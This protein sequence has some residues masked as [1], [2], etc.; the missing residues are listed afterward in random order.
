MTINERHFIGFIR[1]ALMGGD[2]PRGMLTRASWQEQRRL[3]KEQ[4]VSGLLY[5]TVT[6]LP[7][8][9]RPPQQI[10][11]KLYSKV[12]YYENMNQLL[13]ERTLEIFK[14]YREIGLHP[15]L[16]KGPA[17]ATLYEHPEQRVFGDIDIYVPD[18]QNRLYDWATQNA[19]SVSYAPGKEHLL[20]FHWRG[21]TIE[22]HLCLLKFYNKTLA[23]RM[24][25]IVASELGGDY[26]ETFVKI[27]G[28]EVEVLPRTLGL[29]YDIVH[30]SKHLISSGVGLR[31]LCD[32][33]MAMHRYHDE[34]DSEKLCQWFDLLEM[35]PMA[36]AVAAA[37][38]RYLGLKA[39]EVPYNFKTDDIDEKEDE[40]M[41][42]VMDGANFGYWLKRGKKKSLWY[43]MKQTLKQQIR[44]Y[45]YMPREVRTEMWLG[46][47]GKLKV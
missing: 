15:I 21:A 12:V 29:L 27:G 38:V 31:Q 37:A 25:E 13:N 44:I 3:A 32:I 5:Q 39:E 47:I 34:I 14:K 8:E 11:M 40:L 7:Q 16:L 6:Q 45:P 4:T 43:R 41:D 2:Y 24:E 22:N 1:F 26:K 9:L 46:V 30:F 33:T 20:S 23:A 28:E 35:R 18:S 36:N 10:L 17:A 19:E 42:L